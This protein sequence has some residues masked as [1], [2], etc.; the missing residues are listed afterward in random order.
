MI[1][2]N[3]EYRG[4]TVAELIVAMTISAVTL[5]SGYELFVS[6]KTAGDRQSEDLATTA[7]TV[8]G[9]DRI[10]EDLLHAVARAESR[11]PIFIGSN[12]T[13]DDQTQ[14]SP[15]LWFYSLCTGRGEGWARDLRQMCQVSYVLE[16]TKDSVCLYRHCIPVIGTR[17]ASNQELIL[18]GV[19]QIQ[20]TFHNGQQ[21]E[22]SF[23]SKDKL[24][25]GVELTITVSGQKWPL[26]VELPCGGSEGQP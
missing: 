25:V 16:K 6:L 8:H 26:S 15:L 20:V 11:E 18:D 24:P 22:S 2:R 4:F 1:D 17:P 3:R 12:P 21:W 14:T 10:R 13:L 9:L 23:S 19:E 5:L 7:G